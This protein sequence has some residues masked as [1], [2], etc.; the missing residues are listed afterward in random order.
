MTWYSQ[1]YAT[2]VEYRTTGE[3][4]PINFTKAAYKDTYRNHMKSLADTRVYAP[5]AL[6]RVLH[7]L[8]IETIE[9]KS[10]QPSAGS[11]ATLI[12][13]PALTLRALWGHHKCASRYIS[14]QYTPL[15]PNSVNRILNSAINSGKF[16]RKPSR[17]SGN[18][19]PSWPGFARFG[20]KFR[21]GVAKKEIDPT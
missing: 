21:T 12:N 9:T 20:G 3:R 14:S 7:R 2:L 11:S 8:Y 19:V 1:V 17:N 6:G 10:A 4:Q 5:K 16:Q 15:P 13:L 18:L